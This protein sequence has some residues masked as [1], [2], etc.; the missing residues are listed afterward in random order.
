MLHAEWNISRTATS[1]GVGIREP[2]AARARSLL[3]CPV[4][5][6]Y[7]SDSQ[8]INAKEHL[9]GNIVY[10]VGAIVIVIAV[11]SFLGLR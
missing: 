9:M 11:L 3:T 6:F 5:R 10:I 1:V 4:Q 2:V 8:F 7:L